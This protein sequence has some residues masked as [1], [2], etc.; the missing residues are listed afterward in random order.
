MYT[1]RISSTVRL[2]LGGQTLVV[3]DVQG[4]A[5]DE[6]TVLVVGYVDLDETVKVARTL[7][8]VKEGKVVVEVCNASEEDAIIKRGT[9]IAVATVVLARPFPSRQRARKREHLCGRNGLG[10]FRT[11]NG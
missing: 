2:C 1:T 9:L 8:T 10:E 5:V 11:G 3:T 7:C 6:S 4:E